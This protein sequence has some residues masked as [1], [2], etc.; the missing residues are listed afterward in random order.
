MTT[1]F[2]ASFG[3]SPSL[4][5]G[6]D[7]VLEGFVE[8]LEEG[9][10]SSGHAALY[11]GARGARKTAMQ[12]AVEDS[13]RERGWPVVSETATPEFITRIAQQQFAAGSKA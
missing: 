9:P 13:A 4:F 1:P 8:A 10:G 2:G 7:N 6:R 3:V 5:V 11:T 12:N